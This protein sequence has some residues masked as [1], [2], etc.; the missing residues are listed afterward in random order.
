MSHAEHIRSMSH[1]KPVPKFIPSPPPSP[2]S[3]PGAP[4]RQIS[5]SSVSSNSP[6]QTD[7]PPLPEDWRDV[8]DRVVSRERRSTLPTI[9]TVVDFSTHEG[10]SSDLDCEAEPLRQSPASTNFDS[11][12]YTF[13]PP[14]P[15]ESF[16]GDPLSRPHSPTP[17]T[18]PG[19][20][21]KRRAQA[22][23]YRPPTPPLPRVKSR[24]VESECN[25]PTVATHTARNSPP[26]PAPPLSSPPLPPPPLST[27]VRPSRPLPEIPVQDVPDLG[28]C[29]VKQTVPLLRPE[30]IRPSFDQRK[31]ALPT[32]PSSLSIHEYP[33]L[34]YHAGREYA[35]TLASTCTPAHSR[36]P[37]ST[38][39]SEKWTENLSRSGHPVTVKIEPASKEASVE[40]VR[41][42]VETLP[43]IPTNSKP[44]PLREALAQGLKRVGSMVVS[45]FLCRA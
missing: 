42:K 10:P 20:S 12:S 22:K 25:S 28:A 23:E 27:V 39:Y 38:L 5:L 31:A 26:L 1:R 34:T 30:P 18:R 2:P 7:R 37:S 13:P 17:W 15:S 14:S 11:R 33:A 35:T 44:R 43:P 19:G 8:I 29:E 24:S 36:T 21:L 3:S 32:P 16:D 6:V 45:T 4:F 9:N 41:T 40:H